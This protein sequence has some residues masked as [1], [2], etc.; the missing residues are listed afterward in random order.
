MAVQVREGT[1]VAAP[2]DAVRIVPPKRSNETGTVAFGAPAAATPEMTYRGGPILKSVQVFTVFWGSA[3]QSQQSQ[4]AQELNKFFD[5]IVKSPLVDQLKEYDKS[6]AHGAHVGTVTI[7][8]PDPHKHLSDAAL[9]HTLQQEISTNPAFPPPSPNTLYFIFL[10]PG[11][12]LS[13]GGGRSCMSFCGYHDNIQGQIFYAAIPFPGCT[14]CAFGNSALESATIVASH[15][16]GEA[17]T[18]PI[19]GQ[20]WYDDQNGEIGDPC[21]SSTKT[22]GAYT[23]QKLWSNKAKSCV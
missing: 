6:I 5:Y 12:S 23:V 2:G 17:I 3:W 20:G 13:M 4:L 14:G 16:L 18:D 10:P 9:R 7:A 22:L 21:E 11:V 1:I 15:E 8:K 19:P